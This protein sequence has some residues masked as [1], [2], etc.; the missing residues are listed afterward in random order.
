MDPTQ[1]FE[2]TIRREGAF[3]F[4][5]LPFSPRDV[6]GRLPR[7]RVTGEVEGIEV[8]GTLGALGGD[9]FLRLSKAWLAAAGLDVG[10]RVTVR[11]RVETAG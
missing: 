9:Y 8:G 1:A 3:T 6:W 7:Y 2:A 5:P 11:L 10:A 4:I